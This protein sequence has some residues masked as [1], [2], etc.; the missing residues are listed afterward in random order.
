MNFLIL[1]IYLGTFRGRPIDTR[2]LYCTPFQTL[3]R[4]GVA[5]HSLKIT[6]LKHSQQYVSIFYALITTD[7]I[8][9]SWACEPIFPILKQNLTLIY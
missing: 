7:S 1:K 9:I 3:D 4:G 5:S 2:L 6:G 8:I